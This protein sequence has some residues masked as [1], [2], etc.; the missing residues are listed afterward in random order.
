MDG[1]TLSTLISTIGFPIV[2]CLAM[3]YYVKYITDKNNENLIKITEKNNETLNK[4]TDDHKEETLGLTR[5][6]SANTQATLELK[7]LIGQRVA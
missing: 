3:G 4:I 7:S 1:A 6:I 2:A 5:V